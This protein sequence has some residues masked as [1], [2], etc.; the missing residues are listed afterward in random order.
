MACA[1]SSL[2]VPLSPVMS[3]GMV[4]GATCRM[5]SITSRMAADSPMMPSKPY[6]A[7]TCPR[8]EA[9]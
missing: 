8:S 6:A 9:F 4:L 3:T 1:T 7:S 5:V 2:P